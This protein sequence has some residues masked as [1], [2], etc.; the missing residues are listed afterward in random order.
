MQYVNLPINGHN[1]SFVFLTI[2]FGMIG[3]LYAFHNKY[4]K[5]FILSAFG[6]RYA[7]QYLRD[8][9]V[10]KRRV[11]ILFSFLMILNISFFIWSTQETEQNNLSYLGKILLFTITYYLIKY[12]VIWFLGYLLK[13]KQIS[14]IAVFFTTLFDKV[15]ALF[16]FPFLIV[17]HISGFSEL[18]IFSILIL[19]FTLK[20]FWVI[21]IGI[22]SFGL[23]SFYLFLYICIL[24][25]FPL[26]LLYREL[27]F[28]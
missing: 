2:S 19:F 25:F 4:A 21:K 17:F 11:S 9:N 10:F 12:L 5:E 24:E 16:S 6:Q 26:L 20:I 14:T 7:N 1:I 22:K 8:D 15:F 13:M 27:V 3:Y 28:A 18:S 23:S